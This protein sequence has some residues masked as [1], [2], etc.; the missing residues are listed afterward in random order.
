MVTVSAVFM[1]GV[2]NIAA[3]QGFLN[4]FSGFA[5]LISVPLIGM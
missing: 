2:E 4:F 5:A 3:A 1:V